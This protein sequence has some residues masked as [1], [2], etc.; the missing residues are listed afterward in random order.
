MNGRR[1][2]SKRKMET[3]RKRKPRSIAAVHRIRAS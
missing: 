2:E 1:T 3:L